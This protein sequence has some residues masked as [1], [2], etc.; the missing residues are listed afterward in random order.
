MRT[1]SL[2]STQTLDGYDTFTC[3]MFSR[4]GQCLKINRGLLSKTVKPDAPSNSGGQEGAS[5]FL[6]TIGLLDMR[7]NIL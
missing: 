3:L 6:A 1:L 4:N 2:F 7:E 5:G